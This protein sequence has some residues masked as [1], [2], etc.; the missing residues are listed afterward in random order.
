MDKQALKHII[1]ACHRRGRPV[2]V[3]FCAHVPEEILEAAGFRSLRLYH[4][5]GIEDLSGRTLP[6]NLCPAVKVC[7]SLCEGD[8]LDEADLIIAESSCDGKKKMFEIL[9]RQDRLYYYQVP[10]GE[11]RAYVKPLIQSECRHLIGMLQQRFGAEVTEEGLRRACRELNEE[12]ESVMDLLSVQKQVPP[13]AWGR[14]ILDALFQNR[15]IDSP[16][17]RA[18]AN[19]KAQRE[20]LART[21]PVPGHLPRLLVT[22]CPI[23]GVYQKVIAA[24]ENNGGVA[25]CFETCE[26]VKSCRHHVDAG[27]EDLIGAVADCYQD[28]ACAIMSPNALRFSLVKELAETYRV[29]GVVDVTL[30]T[31]H[32]YSIERYKLRRFCGELPVPYLAVETDYSEADMGQLAT[33][34]CAFMEM[35]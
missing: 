17:Q 13:A 5:D 34:L 2:A 22:G 16:L 35:L 8:A 6:K 29:D 33:R 9:S 32:P 31:C 15:Q 23:G 18:A 7:C 24:I 25:V 27:A 21:S 28:T 3:S 10:Q 12:R 30:Q 11:D 20:F 1:A 14:E 4:V 26:T 19:R